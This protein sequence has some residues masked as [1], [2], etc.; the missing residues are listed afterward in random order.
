[1]R[2]NLMVIIIELHLHRLQNKIF[3]LPHQTTSYS[4]CNL[5]NAPYQCTQTRIVVSVVFRRL[6]D[7]RQ[8]TPNA[9]VLLPLY[10][11]IILY[12]LL[13]FREEYLAA[14]TRSLNPPDDKWTVLILWQNCKLLSDKT[15]GRS[16]HKENT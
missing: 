13:L 14:K 15:F 10:Y 9:L 8:R 7:Q 6:H 11:S 2:E 5:I 16:Y 1:M 12:F 3:F 4:H